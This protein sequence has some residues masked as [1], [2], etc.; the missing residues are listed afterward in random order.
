MSDAMILD[1][2]HCSA[3]N[4]VSRAR[5]E[6]G[7]VCGKCKQRLFTGEPVPLTSANFHAMVERS[8]LPVVVDFWASWCGPCKMMAPIFADAARELEPRL[9]FANLNTESE[10]ALAARFGIRSI[11]TLIVFRNGAEVARQPG[12]LQGPELRQ[13]LQPYLA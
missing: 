6:D 13:W 12:L 11:P 5:L 2:P 8:D 10:Q 7:P 4:R 1:C 3:F 9:R